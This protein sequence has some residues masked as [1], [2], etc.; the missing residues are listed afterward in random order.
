MRLV[1]PECTAEY[2]VEDSAVPPT[3][4]DVQCSAC[5]HIWLQA[6]AGGWP[7]EEDA[8]TG[9]ADTEDAGEDTPPGDAREGAPPSD[10]SGAVPEMPA[11]TVLPEAIRD[12]PAEETAEPEAKAGADAGEPE[13]AAERP[14]R[15]N[16]AASPEVIAILREEAEREARARRREGAAG[17]EVQSDLGLVEA[18]PTPP[19]RHKPSIEDAQPRG[20]DRLPAIDEIETARLGP[21]PRPP[22]AASVRAATPEPGE[23]ARGRGRY[24]T[25]FLLSVVLATAAALVYARAGDIATALPE[26]GPALESFVAGV[27]G[28]RLR[29]DDLARAAV[30]ALSA[31]AERAG[32]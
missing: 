11:E 12:M 9:D 14:A 5:G 25:G 13:Q 15:R 21:A 16:P 10:G 6:P 1:C 31:L 8:D 4:R 22:A 30:A 7:E 2:E 29:I 18:E 20:R 17:L 27:D 24:R 28:L 32:G 26:A 3:G 23:G 19:S